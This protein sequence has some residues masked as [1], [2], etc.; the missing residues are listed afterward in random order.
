MT[1]RPTPPPSLDVTALRD[2]AARLDAAL[3]RGAPRSLAQSAAV[4]ALHRLYPPGAGLP[5][6]RAALRL[7]AAQSPRPV[8]P[9]GS[10]APLCPTPPGRALREALVTPWQAE[11]LHEDTAEAA[12]APEA[13]RAAWPAARP[14]PRQAEGLAR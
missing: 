7:L 14:A 3:A 10:V 4:A 12:E 2:I 5:A 8:F 11:E 13:G 9:A 1:D 6:A